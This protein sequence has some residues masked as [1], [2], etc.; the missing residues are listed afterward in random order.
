MKQRPFGIAVAQLGPIQP[1]DSRAQTVA[2]LLELLKEAAGRKADLVVFPELALTTFFPRYWMT[3]QEAQDLYFEK[4]MP[5]PDTQVLFDTAK[6]LGIGFYLGYAE[7]TAD[8][9]AF[10]TSILVNK[11]AEI[12]GR[13]RKIHLPGHTDHKPQAPFQHLEKKFFD[14]GNE[15][16]FVWETMDAKIG[17]CLCNDRR[18][19][20]TWRVLSLQGAELVAVGYNTPAFNIHWQEPAHLRMFHHILSLQAS[21]YQNSVWIAA[22][23]KAGVEDGSHLIGGSAIVSPTGE[24]VA[25]AQSEDDEVIFCEADLALADNFKQHI[26]NLAAHRRPEHYSLILERVGAG[27][28]LGTLPTD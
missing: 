24:I 18:W 26:F 13:Y 2:R 12:V 4:S 6:K 20:E 9:R 5:G 7:L 28:P 3:E 17:M 27:A 16:F 23:A 10:N 22:A 25:L 15:G 19:P 8:G 11:K 14:V 1:T 21:A